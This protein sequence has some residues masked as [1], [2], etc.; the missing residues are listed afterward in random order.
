[1]AKLPS[2]KTRRMDLTAAQSQLLSQLLGQTNVPRA[3]A[4]KFRVFRAEVL[5]KHIEH[6]EWRAAWI[7]EIAKKAALS[8]DA[9]AALDPVIEFFEV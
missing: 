9:W 2:S 6:D 4:A 5:S 8:C 7:G 1:M 3:D